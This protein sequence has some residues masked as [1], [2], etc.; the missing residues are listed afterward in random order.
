MPVVKLAPTET[1][2]FLCDI[3]TRFRS[4][5]YGYDEMVATVNKML[6]IAKV[7]DIPVVVTEQNPRALGTTEPQIPIDSLGALHLGTIEKSLFSM[8]TPEVKSILNTNSHLRSVV[9]LG[10]ESHVCVLQ[11]ALDL[12]ELG[13]NV[14]VIADGISSCNRAEVPIALARIQQAG[15]QITTSESAAFQLQHDATKPNFKAFSSIIKSEVESTKK[16]MEVLCQHRTA[17]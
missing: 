17:L 8:V 12:L 9:L 4:I 10:I 15:G 14:H 11:T 1:V 5:I 7:L 2:L 16:A 3:Q 6:K 13:Y